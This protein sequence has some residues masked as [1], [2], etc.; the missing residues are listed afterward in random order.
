MKPRLRYIYWAGLSFDSERTWAWEMARVE[1]IL[2][3]SER[4][5]VRK[6]CSYLLPDTFKRAR[7][8]KKKSTY[9]VRMLH[10]LCS[11]YSHAPVC[12][13]ETAVITPPTYAVWIPLFILVA[14]SHLAWLG[15]NC[16]QALTRGNRPRSVGRVRPFH[17]PPQPRR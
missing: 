8:Y 14:S 9:Y 6:I 3:E 15:Q 17:F 12:C 4:Y 1:T 11:L 10:T 13:D 5:S 2:L 7:G 16:L